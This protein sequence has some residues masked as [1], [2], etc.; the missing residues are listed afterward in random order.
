MLFNKFYDFWRVV[1]EEFPDLS[2]EQKG[3]LD[4]EP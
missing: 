3:Y 4:K 2:F 1:Q